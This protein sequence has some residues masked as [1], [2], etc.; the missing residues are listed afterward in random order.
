MTVTVGIGELQD[1]RESRRAVF[2]SVSL[3][4]SASHRLFAALLVHLAG[5]VVE[6]V[7]GDGPADRLVMVWKSRL[8]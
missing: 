4:S 3:T 7:G 5:G 8:L 1:N 6:G 2:S